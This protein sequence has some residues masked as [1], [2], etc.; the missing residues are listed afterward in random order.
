MPNLSCKIQVNRMRRTCSEKNH[1]SSYYSVSVK[2]YMLIF[3]YAIA[4]S[5]G[6]GRADEKLFRK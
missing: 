2:F 3:S 5:Y 6:K 4:R 1:S